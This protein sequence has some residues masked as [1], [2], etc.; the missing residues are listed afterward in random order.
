MLELRDL[1]LG[2]AL[3]AI[4][5]QGAIMWRMKWWIVRLLIRM[6]NLAI[7]DESGYSWRDPRTFR[8]IDAA[9]QLET[10]RSTTDY[11]LLRV[12]KGATYNSVLE[13]LTRV[14]AELVRREEARAEDVR[15]WRAGDGA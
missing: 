9:T 1:L 3:F 14:V 4:V 12:P 11:M 6:H 2:V 8:M 10:E 7:Q 5:V 13:A 15:M